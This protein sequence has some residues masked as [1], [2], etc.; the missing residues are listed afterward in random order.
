M[1]NLSYHSM[2]WT[3]TLQI[4]NQASS[5]GPFAAGVVWNHYMDSIV[6]V[7]T[8]LFLLLLLFLIT[9]IL[10]IIITIISYYYITVTMT[11][12]YRLQVVSLGP[13]YSK[14]AALQDPGSTW[15]G[16]LVKQGTHT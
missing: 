2:L 15:E 7:I 4:A 1:R 16:P 13:K 3:D 12:C 6:L 14:V 10:F 5:Q 8:L 9:I 11:M